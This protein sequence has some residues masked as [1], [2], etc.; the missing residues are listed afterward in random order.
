MERMVSKFAN[1]TKLIG[2]ANVL[3]DRIEIQN[4]LDKAEHWDGT[5]KTKLTDVLWIKKKKKLMN[6]H[7]ARTQDGRDQAW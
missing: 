1:N 2:S 7:S 3:D 6:K 5:H 4:G